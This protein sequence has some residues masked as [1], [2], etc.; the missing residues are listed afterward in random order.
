MRIQVQEEDLEDSVRRAARRF[1][2]G[3]TIVAVHHEGSAHALTANSFVTLSLNPALI[4]ISVKTEGRMRRLTEQVRFFGIS[5]LNDGQE[6]Y[7]K[8][9]A[10]RKRVGTPRHLALLSEDTPALAP[11]VPGCVAY[12][13][14]EFDRTYPVGDHD[15]IVGSVLECDVPNGERSPLIFLDGKFQD[16][17]I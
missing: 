15:L 10:D 12:F 16:S 6:D 7:A 4:G 9:Y 11:I 13:V 5:V 8:H 14:C 1:A 3:V 17:T 2:T